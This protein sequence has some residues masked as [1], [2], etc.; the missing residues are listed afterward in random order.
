VF[1]SVGGPATL[2]AESTELQH[3]LI[4]LNYIAVSHVLL[5]EELDMYVEY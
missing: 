3:L 4:F 1:C 5:T 2:N